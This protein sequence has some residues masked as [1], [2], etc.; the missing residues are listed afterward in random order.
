MV[1][2]GLRPSYASFAT[3]YPQEEPVR[4][5]S[6]GRELT[7]DPPAIAA[8]KARWVS[9]RCAARLLGIDIRTLPKI[10]AEARV[11][12]KSI[13]G[14]NSHRYFLQYIQRVARESV[15]TQ[16]GTARPR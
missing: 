2:V 15:K 12:I 8:D 3:L 6:R 9:H 7:D 5:N 1:C 4:Q 14:V 16:T 11:R 13:S 10:A